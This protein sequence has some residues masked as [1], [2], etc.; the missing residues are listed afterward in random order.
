WRGG[1]WYTIGWG[2]DAKKSA[3]LYPTSVSRQY[4]IYHRR[5]APIYGGHQETGLFTTY[6]F[7]S[8][9]LSGSRI[10]LYYFR[11]LSADNYSD[12]SLYSWRMVWNVPMQI[13]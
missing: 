3:A 1:V 4:G 13:L 8:A 5:G 7:Q 12:P 10:S 9:V 2:A 6:Q 11:H